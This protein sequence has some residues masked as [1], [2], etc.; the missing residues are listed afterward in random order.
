MAP[1]SIEDVLAVYP[2]VPEL[3]E[4]HGRAE[5]EKR[6]LAAPAHL[7]LV[8]RDQGQP[9][10]FK[11][12]YQRETDGSFYSWMGGVAHTHRRLGIAQQLAT[13]MERWAKAQGYQS[14]KFTTR[15]CHRAML[16]FALGNGFQ[17]YEVESRP[18][19]DQYRIR[20]VKPL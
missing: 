15:N 8:A 1:G 13:E 14:L 11:V 12:G 6:L 20:L 5:Y 18:T 17:I 7:I 10:G 4:P 9:V 16:L 19:L 2:L 3:V